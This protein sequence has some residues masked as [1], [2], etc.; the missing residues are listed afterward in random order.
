MCAVQEAHAAVVE[1]FLDLPGSSRNTCRKFVSRSY[2]R[3][4]EFHIACKPSYDPSADRNRAPWLLLRAWYFRRSHIEYLWRAFKLTIRNRMRDIRR[5]L[6][7]TPKPASH[8][9]VE[10]VPATTKAAA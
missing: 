10:A 4:A 2:L 8:T 6:K 9:V 1:Q 5:M 3:A 7:R